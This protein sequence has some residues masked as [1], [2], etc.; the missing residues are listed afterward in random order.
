MHVGWYAPMI[1]EK[2]K[3]QMEKWAI[4]LSLLSYTI[5]PIRYN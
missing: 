5:G 3:R 1:I 4:S 2:L